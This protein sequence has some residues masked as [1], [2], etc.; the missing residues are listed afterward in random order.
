MKTNKTTHALGWI[1][2][3]ALASC[4]SPPAPTVQ[5]VK[6]KVSGSLHS[7][8]PASDR[9]F[10]KVNDYRLSRGR[11]ALLRHSGLDRLA[12]EHSEYLRQHRGSF[13][14]SGSNV[15]HI[16]FDGRVAECRHLYQME[17]MS[18]NVLAAKYPGEV[19]A[20]ALLD[21]WIGSN[22]HHKNILDSWTC[23]GVG[24]VQDADGT[25]FSTQLFA[26]INSSP[27]YMRDRISRH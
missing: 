24:V 15:S 12:Q 27:L 14:L 1:C 26:T 4:A 3:G 17:N 19:R 7:A 23:T 5:A 13:S 9:L 25:I 8:N 16:G 20:Q 2:L 22:D 10:E 21:L 11:T 6:M 18:E